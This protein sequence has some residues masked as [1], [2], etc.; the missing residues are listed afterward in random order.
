M[1]GGQRLPRRGYSEGGRLRTAG[2]TQSIGDGSQGRAAHSTALQDCGGFSTGTDLGKESLGPGRALKPELGLNLC[3]LTSSVSHLTS[4]SL[5]VLICGNET[6]I[7]SS[8]GYS[9]N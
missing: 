6:V 9:N 2:D 1:D 5:S 8:P 3:D 4:L 7:H